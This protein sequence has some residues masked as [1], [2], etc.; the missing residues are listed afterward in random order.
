MKS[1]S[2][3]RSEYYCLLE[4]L[5]KQSGISVIYPSCSSVSIRGTDSFPKETVSLILP[6]FLSKS[7]NILR[8]FNRACL[9]RMQLR[10]ELGA[11]L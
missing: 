6:D 7:T 10:A 8:I 5:P 11:R 1:I 3:S 2:K 9:L 4:S